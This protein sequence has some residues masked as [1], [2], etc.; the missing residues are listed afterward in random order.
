MGQ[1]ELGQR[2]QRGGQL[3]GSGLQELESRRRVEEQVADLHD[4]AG[5]PGRRHGPLDLPAGAGHARALGLLPRAGRDAEAGHGA[6][7]RQRLA[8]EPERADGVEVGVLGQLGGGVAL[9]RQ[10]QVLGRHPLPVVGHAHQRGAA[11][12][13]VDGDPARAG[14]QRVLHQLLHDRRRPLDDLAGGDLVD[15]MRRQ[16]PDPSHAGERLRPGAAAT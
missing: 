9:E 8:A 4:G 15:E 11:V 16:P 12:A 2:A 1:R 13:Q 3:G 5:L 6:D 7:G 14:V 10:R